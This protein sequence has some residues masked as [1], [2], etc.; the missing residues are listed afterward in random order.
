MFATLASL[1]NNTDAKGGEDSYNVLPALLGEEIT[2]S[3]EQVRI[4]HSGFDD[5]AIRKGKWK[6]IRKFKE[7]GPGNQFNYSRG[8]NNFGYL[9][10]LSTDPYETTDLWDQEPEIVEELL[11]IFRNMQN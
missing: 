4:F 3:E 11:E 5:F 7:V 1:V 8:P 9:Y 10:D 2:N 6:L